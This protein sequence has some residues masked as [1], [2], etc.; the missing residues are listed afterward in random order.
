MTILVRQIFGNL[1]HGINL[2][3]ILWSITVNPLV[4]A[5]F[6]LSRSLNLTAKNHSWDE[7]D[8]WMRL[9]KRVIRS[10]SFLTNYIALHFTWYKR[11]FEDT[12]TVKFHANEIVFPTIQYDEQYDEQRIHS[13]FGASM[14]FDESSGFNLK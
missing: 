11:L 12:S 13:F 1:N 2:L 9:V 14:A 7:N 3:K 5:R 8:M 4:F 10:I 6:S